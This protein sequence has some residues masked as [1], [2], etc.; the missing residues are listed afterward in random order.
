M[1]SYWLHGP[2][3]VPVEGL[4]RGVTTRT[5]GL[6]GVLLEAA[7]RRPSAGRKRAEAK[8]HDHGVSANMTTGCQHPSPLFWTPPLEVTWLAGGGHVAQAWLIGLNLGLLPALIREFG[9]P[10][11]PS[12]LS[13][14]R[15]P[16]PRA[17]LS[18]RH[19]SLLMSEVQ[20]S[21][22]AQEMQRERGREREGQTE[23]HPSSEPHMQPCL[24]SS[25]L[26]ISASEARPSC[27]S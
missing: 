9:C 7:L 23:P 17:T 12:L 16:M 18:P 27:C 24:Q 22:V 15:Q 14:Q 26:T 5:L 3:L 8:Q 21:E 20:T 25:L 10:L 11:P 4:P 19:K 1:I 13:W 6:L 2:A